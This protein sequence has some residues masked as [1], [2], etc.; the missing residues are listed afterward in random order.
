MKLTKIKAGQ[1]KGKYEGNHGVVYNE[2]QARKLAPELFTT[3]K[4]KAVKSKRNK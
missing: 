2:E 4:K 1:H 3:A